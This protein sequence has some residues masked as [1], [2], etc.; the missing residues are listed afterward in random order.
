MVASVGEGVYL[1][2]P[3]N[4]TTKKDD[5]SLI[6][7]CTWL[8]GATNRRINKYIQGYHMLYPNSAL[9]VIT[10][11][12]ADITILPFAALHAR[13]QPA[14]DIIQKFA[15][16]HSKPSMLLHLFSHGGG[17]TAIQLMQSLHSETSAKRND[18]D[19]RDHLRGIILDCCPG[20]AAFQRSFHA[21]AESLPNNGLAKG[22]GK[23]LLVPFIGTI[24]GLQA[25]GAMRSIQHLRAELNDPNIF[26]ST[27]RRLY[28]YSKADAVVRW[29]DVESH[30]EDAQSVHN[31]TATGTV[32][33]ESAHC[34]IIRDHA[35]H[36]WK[37]IERFW[38]D[39]GSAIQS[40]L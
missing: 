6:V 28:L 14:R 12:V 17:N 15:Q 37:T 38:G 5:P 7:L 2:E 1:Y 13:L 4:S 23:A 18:I 34:S 10:T 25:I 31:Y 26:G 22:I 33:S 8:G 3:S 29:E 21:A 16:Q 36:Y 11:V 32:F 20:D 30:L 40:R 35:E 27:A 39:K 9:M 19:I 24:M